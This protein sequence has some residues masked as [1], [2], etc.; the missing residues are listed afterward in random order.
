MVETAESFM[1][2][3]NAYDAETA[4]SLLTDGPVKA[5]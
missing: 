4:I 1:E 2:A 3:R 5:R